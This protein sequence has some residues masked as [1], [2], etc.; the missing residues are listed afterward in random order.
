MPAFSDSSE[1]YDDLEIVTLTGDEGRSLDCYIENTVEVDGATFL[2]LLPVDSPIV[3]LAWD[4]N[5]EEE[6]ASEA[7]FVEDPEEI[8]E[9]FE[10]AKA[11][12]AE[13][14]LTLQHTAFTLTAKGELPPLEEDDLLSLELDDSDTQSDVEEL[15][16]LASF[17]FEEQKYGIYTPLAP[18]L[19]VA[20]QDPAGKL[21]LLSPEEPQLQ[22]ILEEL[23]FEETEEFE[24]AEE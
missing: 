18:L 24:E 11:V 8:E 1:Q 12:L 23:L 16:F 6:E 7:A 10:D 5:L 9:V 22:E 15:Q 13:L 20:R 3:L 14:D 21:E 19:F 2:L 17:Y 4:D